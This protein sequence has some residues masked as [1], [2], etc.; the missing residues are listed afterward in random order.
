MAIKVVF[1][2]IGDTLVT[3]KSWLPGAQTVLGKLREKGIRIGLISNTGDLTRDELATEYLPT[4]FDFG[5]FDEEIVL[6]SSEVGVEKPALS[7]FTMA[8]NHAGVSPWETLFVAETLEE[9]WA[10]QASGMRAVRVCQTP[11]DLEKIAELVG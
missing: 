2:D 6:L 9:T 4:D 8:V 3:R 1:F 11:A 10:A 7:I 5:W